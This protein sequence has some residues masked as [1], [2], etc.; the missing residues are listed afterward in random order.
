MPVR[1]GIV[2]SP[3]ARSASKAPPE[4]PAVVPIHEPR[5][6]PFV[7]RLVIVGKRK[8]SIFATGVLLEGLLSVQKTPA[9]AQGGQHDQHNETQAH[10]ALRV[11]RFQWERS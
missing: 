11:A 6:G 4:T 5:P 8:I 2:C 9:T 10:S 3:G 7:R 1:S